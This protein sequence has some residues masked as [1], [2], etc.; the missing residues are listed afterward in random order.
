MSSKTRAGLLDAYDK[1]LHPFIGQL[2]QMGKIVLV[3]SDEFFA[4]R[5]KG[6]ILSFVDKLSDMS[7][8]K[9]ELTEGKHV[10]DAKAKLADTNS[11]SKRQEAWYN[12]TLTRVSLRQCPEV[13]IL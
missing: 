11:L 12:T 5:Q 3:K 2:E 4:E 9:E 1:A 7:S 8:K 10:I 6:F 13:T